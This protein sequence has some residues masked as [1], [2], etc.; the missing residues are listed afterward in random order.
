[1]RRNSSI[2]TYLQADDSCSIHLPR[3]RPGFWLL[4]N[5]GRPGFFNSSN[6]MWPYSWNKCYPENPTGYSGYDYLQGSKNNGC[7]A[8]P[9]Y[10][11]EPFVARTM[12]ELDI[13]EVMIISSQVNSTIDSRSVASLQLAPLMVRRDDQKPFLPI[14]QLSLSPPCRQK[15]SRSLTTRLKMVSALSPPSQSSSK[16][17][18][19]RDHLMDQ[20]MVGLACVSAIP[21]MEP[22]QSARGGALQTSRILCQ[23]DT[24]LE[25]SYKTQ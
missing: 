2:S 21:L 19:A 5:L 1:M 8:N 23:R 6:R 18:G 4:G 22:M 9:P 10:G 17:S 11:W 16:T 24:D 13:F 14:I 20:Q 3:F 12:P 15:G 7:D 25:M